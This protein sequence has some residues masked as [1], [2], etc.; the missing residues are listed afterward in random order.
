MSLIGGY[1]SRTHLVRCNFSHEKMWSWILFLFDIL[2][3]VPINSYEV[4]LTI[5]TMKVIFIAMNTSWS[6]AKNRVFSLLAQLV[7][8]CTY[9]AEVMGSNPVWAWSF[10][11]RPYFYHCLSST[12]YCKD[13]FHI[14][15]FI[16]SSDDFCIF[17][18]RKGNSL[19]LLNVW[20]LLIQQY[21]HIKQGV[22]TSIF[23]CLTWKV[24]WEVEHL[25]HQ[26]NFPP[27]ILR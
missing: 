20:K 26:Q 16:C 6:M 1:Y 21:L 18:V 8:H 5:W 2:Q 15:F 14:Y 4:L 22:I 19:K 10:F 27:L 7:E 11:F 12:H 23:V 24:I 3:W 9:I 17:T 13:C 25:D